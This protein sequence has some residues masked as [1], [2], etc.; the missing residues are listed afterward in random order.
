MDKEFFLEGKGQGL[1]RKQG[2]IPAWDHGGD[3]YGRPAELDFSVNL[4][5]LGMPPGVE[6]VLKQNLASLCT[7]YP[8]PYCRKLRAALAEREGAP[9]E[10]ILCANGA[11]ELL[12][13]AAAA[14]A[15][16]RG[17]AAARPLRALLCV[18]A[19]SEY[20][21]A[22]RAAGAEPRFFDLRTESGVSGDSA[23]TDSVSPDS[24]TLSGKETF[25]LTERFLEELDDS[26]DMVFL[27]NPGNPSGKLIDPELLE[28]IL[29]L[30]HSR[31]IRLVLDEC[32]LD[33]SGEED[34]RSGKRYLQQ[35]PELLVVKAFTKKYALPGL[36]LGYGLCADTAFLQSLKETLPAWNVSSL[37]QAAGLAALEESKYWERS[38]CLLQEERPLLQAGLTALG[39]FVYPSDANFLLF[40][41]GRPDLK[42][43]LLEQG[44]L[45]RDCAD[46]RGLTKGFYRAAVKKHEEN[47]RLLAALETVLRS[48]GAG[49]QPAEPRKRC[50]GREE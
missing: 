4:N 7:A 28:R 3:I 10:Q 44:L 43:R 50:F 31:H 14:E 30:C 41:C 5:P 18:P 33:F 48:T 37:A 38:L 46:F 40:R 23:P 27:C 13:G 42:E 25:S 15:K 8:D 1:C 20:E 16:L 35:C 39:C 17:Q 11:C 47:K 21:K 9:A 49:M 26:T 12:Y 29:D 22:L 45:I 34:R 19:F 24:N 36:R 6:E 32:F 2:F